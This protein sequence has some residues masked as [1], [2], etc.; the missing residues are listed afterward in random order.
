MRG[1]TYR[2]RGISAM[3]ISSGEERENERAITVP[4]NLA[5]SPQR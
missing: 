5:C 1:E 3:M 4:A 2:A